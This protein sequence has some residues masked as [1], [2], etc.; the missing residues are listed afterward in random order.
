MFSHGWLGVVGIVQGTGRQCRQGMGRQ[1]RARTAGKAC[2]GLARIGLDWQAWRE[3]AWTG[4]PLQDI[5]GK[6][7]NGQ[8]RTGLDCY[9]AAGMTRHD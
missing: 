3:P 6:A 9:G 1:C 2:W 7:R 5:A 4:I 8:A